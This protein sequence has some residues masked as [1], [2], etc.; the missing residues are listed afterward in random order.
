MGGRSGPRYQGRITT[1]KD[2]QGFGFIT[3]NGGGPPVFVHVKSFAGRGR[4]P[5][6]N[7]LVTYELSANDKGQPRAGNVA[8]VRAPAARRRSADSPGR[9]PA[10]A[11]VAFLLLLALSVLAGKMPAPVLYFYLGASAVTLVAYRLDKS[12]AR[13]NRWRTRESTLHLFS[14]LGGWPGALIAQHSFRHK[15]S[16]LSFRQVFWLTVAANCGALAWLASAFR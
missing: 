10:V 13:S 16:K 1:W 12:A 5:G 3:P 9:A 6:E 2:E 14:L 11:A 15:S 7:D 4:R 8:F